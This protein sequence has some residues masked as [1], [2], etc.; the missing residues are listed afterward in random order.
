M[1]DIDTGALK[2]GLVVGGGLLALLFAG[3]VLAVA[4]RWAGRALSSAVFILLALGA[5]YAA[6]QLYAGWT[7]AEEESTGG[8]TD[9]ETDVLT[10]PDDVRS[11]YVDGGMSEQE[12]E[13]EL[14]EIIEQDGAG[15]GDVES[16]LN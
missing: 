12:L 7:R 4:T 5:G 8:G 13:A 14:E 11:A 3:Q 2:L 9:F 15:E 16:E 1:A 10:D 6:T